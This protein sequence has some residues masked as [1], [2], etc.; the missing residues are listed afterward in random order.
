MSLL[1]QPLLSDKSGNAPTWNF[2][3]YLVNTNGH[4]IG[5]WGPQTDVEGIFNEVRAAVLAAVEKGKLE[6]VK[7]DEQDTAEVKMEQ[8]KNTHQ[9]EHED[10]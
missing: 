2:W 3:K 4:V 1:I 10:L 7:K 9:S 5:S 6:D 8:A